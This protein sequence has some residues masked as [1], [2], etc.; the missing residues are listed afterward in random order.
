MQGINPEIML[1]I[2]ETSRMNWGMKPEALPPNLSGK[3][4]QIAP[5]EAIRYLDPWRGS[6]PERV[7]QFRDWRYVAMQVLHPNGGPFRLISIFDALLIWDTGEIEATDEEFSIE[8]GHC[9]TKTV[10]RELAALERLGLIIRDIKWITKGEKKVRGRRIRLAV[11]SDLNA[12]IR[13]F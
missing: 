5:V 11:P 9:G 1:S 6:L 13:D 12:H 10:S 4:K 8:A 7:K 3:R 2:R